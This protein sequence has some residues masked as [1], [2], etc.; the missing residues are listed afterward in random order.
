MVSSVVQVSQTIERE[1]GDSMGDMF[2]DFV[3]TPLA[4]ASVRF[5]NSNW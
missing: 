4:T 3:E 1:L 5:S 2:M